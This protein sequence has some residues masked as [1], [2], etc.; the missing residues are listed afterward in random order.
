M[1]TLEGTIES[2][3]FFN[4]DNGYSVLKL[5][6][7]DGIRSTIVGTFPP[8]SAGER[9]KL[10]GDW[11]TSPKFGPQFKAASF[12]A[13]LPT[14]LKGI[15]KYLS[16]GLIKGIGPALAARI[17]A[18]FGDRTLDVLDRQ[19]ERM[20]EVQGIGAAKL[21]DIRESWAEHTDIRDLIIFLQEH[22]VSTNLANKIHR[23]YGARAYEVLKTNPYQLCLD[24]WGIGFKTADGIA[25]KLG[26]DPA[27]PERIKAYLLYL[28]EKDNEQGHVFSYASALVPAAAE[29]LGIDEDR[30]RRA[31]EALNAARAVVMEPVG[32]DS[33]VYRPFY[34]EAQEEVVRSI[35]N[36]SRAP[37]QAPP[38]F[39]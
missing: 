12:Q 7:D 2:V 31:L 38:A 30:V 37:F 3:L 32:A 36:L 23:Q 25:L 26:I 24:I 6:A 33:A 15:E 29:E 27:S 18:K 28:L 5:T 16:C 14:G 22:D 8:F 4:P 10:A 9:L 20:T 21:R 13:V 1:E 34:Y 19:P 17:L 39:P 35:E 11:E